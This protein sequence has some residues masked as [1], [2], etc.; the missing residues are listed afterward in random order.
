MLSDME[1]L[2]EKMSESGY[3]TSFPL[4]LG[5]LRSQDILFLT[6]FLTWFWCFHVG[7]LT[8]W[9]L[10]HAD[11]FRR[12]VLKHASES[13]IMTID[14]LQIVQGIFHMEFPWWYAMHISSEIDLSATSGWLTQTSARPDWN[15]P[16]VKSS[17]LWTFY[18][19]FKWKK[20]T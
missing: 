15:S 8:L 11:N 7:F 12:N 5:I 16:W 14:F 20:S 4:C 6:W 9:P 17:I 1:I 18:F 13:H 2:P 19:I 3:S 10:V